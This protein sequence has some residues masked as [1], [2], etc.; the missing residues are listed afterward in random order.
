M[1]RE[2][3]FELAQQADVWI[4][5]QAPYQEQ[6]E[7]FANLIEAEVHEKN[8]RLCDSLSPAKREFDERFY[9]A[10]HVCADAIRS[11]A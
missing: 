3:V 2:K 11:Q 6:L 1:N 9:D 5:G 8:A 10:C 4:A 7:R